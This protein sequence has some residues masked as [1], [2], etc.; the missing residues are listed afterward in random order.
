MEYKTLSK[1]KKEFPYY[2]N[3]NGDNILYDLHYLGEHQVSQDMV[4]QILPEI[5]KKNGYLSSERS[6]YG[7]VVAHEEKECEVHM[8]I[9]F[10]CVHIYNERTGKRLYT[11]KTAC[12][13]QEVYYP[14]NIYG[15]VYWNQMPSEVAQLGT[16]STP[17]TQKIPETRDIYI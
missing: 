6:C 1:M 13:L 14:Y 10:S 9:D 4:E 7:I 8:D 15:E 16:L 17:M 3:S 12:G 11:V 5:Y 2:K